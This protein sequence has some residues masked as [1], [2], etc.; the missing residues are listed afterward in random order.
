MENVTLTND[1]AGLDRM[2]QLDE[3]YLMLRPVCRHLYDLV[4][5]TEITGVG[6]D[7]LWF[8][9]PGATTRIEVAWSY[10]MGQVFVALMGERIGDATYGVREY[11]HGNYFD[12]HDLDGIMAHVLRCCEMCGIH[13]SSVLK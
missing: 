10:E 8:G 7:Y 12:E 2:L 6:H 5:D 3:A 1:L 13:E 11:H 4:K 9:A